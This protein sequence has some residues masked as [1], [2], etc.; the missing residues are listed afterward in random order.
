VES[1]LGEFDAMTILAIRDAVDTA[2]FGKVNYLRKQL[3]D[4][5]ETKSE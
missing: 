1:R 2:L 5:A 4:F 3:G